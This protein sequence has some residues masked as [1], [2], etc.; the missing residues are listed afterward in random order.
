MSA[1][2]SWQA[3]PA[4]RL[5]FQPAVASGVRTAPFL[6]IHRSKTHQILTS[7]DSRRVEPQ[8]RHRRLQ[9]LRLPAG[10]FND[11]TFQMRIGHSLHFMHACPGFGSPAH[12]ITRKLSF[13][14]MH[15]HSRAVIVSAPPLFFT[16][17]LPL[18]I[19]SPE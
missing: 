5:S 7:G 14:S 12:A 6:V 18:P 16:S 13:L 10:N 17:S 15:L 3:T 2:T 9:S 8:L 11:F 4:M 19:F 1:S